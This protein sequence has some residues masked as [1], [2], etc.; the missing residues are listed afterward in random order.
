MDLTIEMSF[1]LSV[2][3]AEMA[4]FMAGDVGLCA[5]KAT[6]HR[7]PDTPWERWSLVLFFALDGDFVVRPLP[8]FVSAERPAA[9]EPV[10]QDEH[11]R[12]ELDRASEN[13]AKG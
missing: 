9:Y 2:S 1:C 3:R 13:A 6:G 4:A 10:S 12:A 11:I 5:F 7:V 8:R